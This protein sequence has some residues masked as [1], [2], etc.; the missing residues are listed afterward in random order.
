MPKPM[1]AHVSQIRMS[2]QKIPPPQAWRSWIEAL[3][4]GLSEDCM[5][6]R[7]VNSISSQR[8]VFFDE[9]F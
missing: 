7:L 8:Y 9:I 2:G 3:A 1:E 6:V 5:S 4:I